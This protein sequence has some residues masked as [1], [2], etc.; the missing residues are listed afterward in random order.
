VMC[1]HGRRRGAPIERWLARAAVAA[2]WI[3]RSRGGSVVENVV[4][5]S[6]GGLDLLPAVST[7]EQ[8]EVYTLASV[9]E[10][11]VTALA[12]YVRVEVEYYA[13]GV[14]KEDEV[15]WKEAANDD[16]V[17]LIHYLPANASALAGFPASRSG[18][19]PDASA[20]VAISTEF[21]SDDWE[22]STFVGR[23]SGESFSNL[24][25]KLKRF[26]SNYP[27]YAGTLATGWEAQVSPTASSTGF[28]RWCLGVL[29]ATG[30]ILAPVVPTKVATLAYAA[31]ASPRAA[32]SDESRLF[33]QFL[34]DCAAA[35][36]AQQQG[37]ELGVTPHSELARNEVANLVTDCYND[38]TISPPPFAV[39]LSTLDASPLLLSV[40]AFEYKVE[41][42]EPDKPDDD[43]QSPK[44]G[45]FVD[46]LLTLALVIALAAGIRAFIRKTGLTKACGA[47][48]PRAHR[49]DLY[50]RL[51]HS[52][53]LQLEPTRS[54]PSG[55][56]TFERSRASP[57]PHAAAAGGKPR[58]DQE[59]G[60]V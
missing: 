49:S 4:K 35:Y 43:D 51:Q 25:S 28:V 40:P 37:D 22:S 45:D 21:D 5:V 29:S 12:P 7:T 33:G 9:V 14:R 42:L 1:K 57:P 60:F 20:S 39:L 46:W 15:S 53:E 24:V 11:K 44:Q 13:V 8:V 34:H 54:T 23:V 55:S 50:Q 31:D 19:F 2:A 6:E 26:Q 32:S 47:H 30:A 36:Y 16:G 48:S 3:P 27:R 41:P 38:T 59:G 17:Y 18:E 52:G 10:V 58:L 56:V